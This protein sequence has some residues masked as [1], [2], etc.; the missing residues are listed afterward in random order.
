MTI[1]SSIIVISFGLILPTLADEK[2]VFGGDG[3]IPTIQTG[4]GCRTIGGPAEGQNCKFPFFFKGILRDG[5]ITELDPEAKMKKSIFKNRKM[6]PQ[7]SL[8]IM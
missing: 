8:M 7:S 1:Y 4:S 3:G 2:V 6:C 5:C